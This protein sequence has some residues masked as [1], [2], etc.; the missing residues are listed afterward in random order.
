MPTYLVAYD[1]SN[2]RRLRKVARQLEKV[3]T[4]I[5]YSVFLLKGEREKLDLLFQR[6]ARVIHPHKD[7]IQAW[8]LPQAPAS[9]SQALGH[10]L[11]THAAALVVGEQA[12]LFV[13]RAPRASRRS[14]AAESS[15]ISTEHSN[16]KETS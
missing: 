1:I 2:P 10:L 15:W 7:V 5:Q 16:P 8:E 3:A 6:L 14:S 11:P 9:K 13:V 4:R 12:K